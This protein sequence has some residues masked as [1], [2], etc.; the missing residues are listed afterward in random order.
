MKSLVLA[1]LYV[2]LI[3]GSCEKHQVRIESKACKVGTY[4]AQVPYQGEWKDAKVGV[5]CP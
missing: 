5:S 1:T 3:D 2:C 4:E